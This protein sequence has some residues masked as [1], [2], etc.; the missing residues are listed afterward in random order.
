M[1][2]VAVYLQEQLGD[3]APIKWLPAKWPSRCFEFKTKEEALAA[4]PEA[5]ILSHEEL[6]GY[7]KALQSEFDSVKPK[8]EPTEEEKAA[9]PW[10]KL[11]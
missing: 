9:D 8:P 11:W 7:K 6:K 10:W 5:L 2:Y 4:H 3:K 1:I